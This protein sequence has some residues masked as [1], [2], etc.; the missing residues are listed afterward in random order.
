M[1]GL[2][3]NSEWTSHMR[4]NEQVKFQGQLKRLYTTN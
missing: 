2:N 3:E 4:W 1:L